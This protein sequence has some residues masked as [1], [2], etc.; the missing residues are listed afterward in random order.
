MR[1]IKAKLRKPATTSKD[2]WSK[3]DQRIWHSV[4]VNQPAKLASKLAK[5]ENVNVNKMCPS[6]GYSVLHYAAAKGLDD[7]LNVLLAH[8]AN[9]AI[10]DVTGATPL[11][12]SARYGHKGATLKLLASRTVDVNAADANRCTALHFASFEGHLE[13]VKLLEEANGIN[14]HCLDKEGRTA[15]M[16]A[17]AMGQLHVCSELIQSGID[18]NHKDSSK[19]QHSALTLAAEAGHSDVVRLL[20]ENGASY[21]TPLTDGRNALDVARSRSRRGVVDVLHIMQLTDA[22]KKNDRDS[23]LSTSSILSSNAT[24]ED[25]T[26]RKSSQVD[27]PVHVDGVPYIDEIAVG[28]HHNI[29]TKED[30]QPDTKSE[31]GPALSIYNDSKNMSHLYD[32]DISLYDSKSTL[33]SVSSLDVSQETSRTQSPSLARLNLDRSKN[34]EREVVEQVEVMELM[35]EVE[36]LKRSSEK[37]EALVQSLKTENKSLTHDLENAKERQKSLSHELEK[38]NEKQKSLV[39]TAKAERK[40]LEAQHCINKQNEAEIEKLN[41]ELENLKTKSTQLDEESLKTENKSLTH[42]LE[43][44]KERQKS[45]SQELEKSNEKQK[46]LVNTA[47]AERKKLEAQHCINKQNEAEIEKLNKELENLKTKSTQLEEESLKTENKSLTQDLEDAKE[48]QKLLSQEL[49]KSNEKQK[50]LVNT[51]KAERKK[52]EAQHCINKQ[53]EAEIE[54]LNKEL[55][56]LKTKSTQLD[57]ENVRVSEDKEIEISYFHDLLEESMQKV[58]LNGISD[59]YE[60]NLNLIIQEIHQLRQGKI[61]KV[62]TLEEKKLEL[63]DLNKQLTQQKDEIEI[64]RQKVTD[65][66]EDCEKLGQEKSKLE[67]ELQ[68]T[69]ATTQDAQ[70][71]WNER[72]LRYIEDE[73]KWH[74]L[75]KEQKYENTKLREKMKGLKSD[76]SED[77]KKARKMWEE[78]EELLK[79]QMADVQSKLEDARV[80]YESA[81][82]KLLESEKMVSELRVE[83]NQ[84]EAKI[85][86]LG[87]E[88][89]KFENQKK[90]NEVESNQARQQLTEAK[91]RCSELSEEVSNL[92]I[93][94]KGLNG[95]LVSLDLQYGKAEHEKINSM[96]QQLETLCLHI[97]ESERKYNQTI[98]VYRRHLLRAAK[99]DLHPQ[100]MHACKEI[101]KLQNESTSNEETI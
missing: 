34:M 18:V 53:N 63:N 79:S 61:K 14:I 71:S 95:K 93:N 77:Q 56:N 80:K 100:V 21:T 99:G 17:S 26:S 101:I 27:P 52:L 65:S 3:V 66:Q 15:L 97:Q 64:L 9:V 48:R 2:D 72:E 20:C 4:A 59:D 23:R 37:S 44:A 6:V 67:L 58:E 31:S 78:G 32:R 84:R 24:S 10:R 47:K 40:K 94:I 76:L 49:E 75:L 98:S 69:K 89:G 19:L 5:H 96:N 57:E 55:E 43:N 60:E 22:A 38:S 88:L 92:R 46:S 45:L 11:H 82:H 74:T 29:Q 28:T 51:A 41:K 90:E 42:D 35:K 87:R 83:R 68:V 73:K 39:N 81:N 86:E 91:Q 85:S 25:K 7:C 50:S 33:A 70:E 54:K 12:A 36:A 30:K 1:S 8:K 62:E 13:C 16:V